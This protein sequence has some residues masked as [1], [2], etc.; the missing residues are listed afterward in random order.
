MPGLPGQRVPRLRPIHPASDETRAVLS[1]KPAVRAL[2]AAD[3]SG[4]PAPDGTG[5]VGKLR[6]R[7]NA[8]FTETAAAAAEANEH[9]DG[10]KHHP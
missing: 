6:I 1:A 7:A 2:P 10:S 4:V 8:A 3:A 5:I 9:A